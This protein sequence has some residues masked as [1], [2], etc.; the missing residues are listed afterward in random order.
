MI[1][2][3]EESESPENS[4]LRK[5]NMASSGTPVSFAQSRSTLIGLL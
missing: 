4:G 5:K 3:V 2:L 1:D